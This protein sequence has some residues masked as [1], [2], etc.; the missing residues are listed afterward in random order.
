MFAV[1]RKRTG[2]RDYLFQHSCEIV[3]SVPLGCTA[4]AAEFLASLDLSLIYHHIPETLSPEM[5]VYEPDN[6]GV[7]QSN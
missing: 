5:T 6:A 4:E 3:E 7:E 2:R 1:E